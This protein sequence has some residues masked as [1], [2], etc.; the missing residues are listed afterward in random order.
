MSQPSMTRMVDISMMLHCCVRFVKKM[1][2]ALNLHE[3]LK[4]FNGDLKVPG[5]NCESLIL[6]KTM[7][8]NTAFIPVEHLLQLEIPGGW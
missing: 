5:S 4:D 1:K 7:L 3:G 8:K 6:G 2:F